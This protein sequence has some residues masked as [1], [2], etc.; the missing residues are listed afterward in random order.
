MVILTNNENGDSKELV[1]SRKLF[2]IELTEV[3]FWRFIFLEL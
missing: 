2:E 3:H 1:I